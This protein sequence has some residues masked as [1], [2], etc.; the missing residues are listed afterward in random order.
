MSPVVTVASNFSN[1]D[2]YERQMGRWSRRLAEPF[3]DFAG[4]SAGEEVLDVGCGTGSLT[5]AI[6]KR[7]N[8][9]SIQGVDLTPAFIDAAKSKSSDARIDFRVADVCALPFPDATFDR[10]LSL[11]CLHFVPK[12]EVAVRELRRVARPGATVAAAVWDARGGFVAQ[13]IF[14]DTAAMV[15]EK[16][17]EARA[18]QLTRPLSQPEQLEAAWRSAG[19]ENVTQSTVATRMEYSSFD[20]FWEP[21][22]GGQGGAA[23]YVSTLNEERRKRLKDGVR[24]AYLDGEVDGPR[25]YAAIAWAVRGTAPL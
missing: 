17:A 4:V 7:A 25:S 1:S 6:P 22:L 11:L 5:Y 20:D 13:R 24:L 19:F 8:V 12:T 23:S 9:R 16:G 21:Y 15:D 10:V 18:Q 14:Y 3:L 2:A